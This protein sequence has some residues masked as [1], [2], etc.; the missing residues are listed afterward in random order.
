MSSKIFFLAI[1]FASVL[2]SAVWIMGDLQNQSTL[3]FFGTAETDSR[4]ISLEFPVVVQRIL[5]Q[6]GSRV[7]QGDTL[8][9]M[10]RT[11]FDREASEYL[12]EMKKAS[13]ELLAENKS[14]ER[15]HEELMAKFAT[16]IAEL[17][18][19]IRVLKSETDI[20]ENLKT[21]LSG[22]EKKWGNTDI[23]NAKKSQIAAL[24]ESILQLERLRQEEIRQFEKQ[25]LANQAVHDAKVSQ[26][27][28]LIEFV[29]AERKKM[30]LLA[31][32]SGYV[33][34]VY[35][36]KNEAVDEFRELFKINALQPIRVLCFLHETETE[37][38]V[39]P[40]DTVDL[41]STARPTV[42]CRGIVAGSSPKLVELPTRLRKFAEVRTWGRVMFIHLPDTNRFYTGEKIQ[43]NVQPTTPSKLG[44]GQ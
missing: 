26:L 6:P 30:V 41:A 20:Q 7:E 16:Q 1:L 2:A 5:V 27:R 10:Y 40:G 12:G 39:Q 31:P 15:E 21:V 28:R 38:L 19:E 17:R 29:D 14:L 13:A 43:I 8:A 11:E 33:E 9:V 35:I 32:I 36:N 23:P 18:A 25:R 3:T 4:T 42:T 24:E 37:V 22:T 44:K 34:Q